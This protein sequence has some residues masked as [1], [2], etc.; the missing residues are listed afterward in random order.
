VICRWISLLLIYLAGADMNLVILQDTQRLG[1]G[2]SAPAGYRYARPDSGSGSRISGTGLVPS[3]IRAEQRLNSLRADK[4]SDE[5]NLSSAEIHQIH[6]A[7]CVIFHTLGHYAKPGL[8]ALR[9]LRLFV[10][11]RL[12]RAMLSRVRPAAGRL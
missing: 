3:Q 6:G 7:N 12:C 4:L 10:R 8:G 2:Y 9:A 1:V 11:S 5:Y